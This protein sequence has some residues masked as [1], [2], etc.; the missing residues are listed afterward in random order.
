[1]KPSASD[2]WIANPLHIDDLQTQTPNPSLHPPSWGLGCGGGRGRGASGG[3]EGRS[4]L[5]ASEPAALATLAMPRRPPRSLDAPST[6][7]EDSP[8]GDKTLWGISAPRP[9]AGSV[10]PRNPWEGLLQDSWG[11]AGP[12]GP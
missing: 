9:W 7:F 5:S 11:P 3:G 8:G 2:F 1:M 6:N 12:S 10:G 4:G